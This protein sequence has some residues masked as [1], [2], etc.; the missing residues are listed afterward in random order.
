MKRLL[1]MSRVPIF[2]VLVLSAATTA[3]AQ[4]PCEE[5]RDDRYVERMML[6][7][8]G[9]EAADFDAVLEHLN[10]T[11]EQFDYAVLDYSRARALHNLDRFEEAA[12]AY[13]RFLRHFEDCPDPDGLADAARNYRTLAIQQQSSLVAIEPEPL[14]TEPT[15]TDPADTDSGSTDTALADT[16]LAVTD[17]VTLQPDESLN[18]GWYVIGGGGA[19]LLAGVV[20]DLINLDL[21]D[22]GTEEDF[23]TARLFDGLLYGSGILVAGVGVALLFLLDDDP[24]EEVVA[25][26]GVD[27]TPLEDGALLRVRV[28]WGF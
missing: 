8:D 23:S 10:W 4:D 19:L 11:I 22:E 18:P 20:Y 27:I 25:P 17:E 21:L 28:P 15:D 24:I 16:D 26:V 12:A 7:L 6:V 2:T 14:D 3:Y 5:P 9:I 13:N 1:D